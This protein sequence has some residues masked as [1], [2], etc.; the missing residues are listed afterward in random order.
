M[1]PCLGLVLSGGLWEA[2]EGL[3][4]PLHRRRSG[5]FAASPGFR[6]IPL[7]GSSD[8]DKENYLL[9][10]TDAIFTTLPEEKMEDLSVKKVREG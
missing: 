3:V 9:A 1:P 10:N 6:P 8:E 4:P 7:P 5:A 2:A